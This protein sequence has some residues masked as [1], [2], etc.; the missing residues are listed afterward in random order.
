MQE[1]RRRVVG[2]VEQQNN[3]SDGRVEGEVHP[4]TLS[5]QL[6]CARKGS[7]NAHEGQM[8]GMDTTVCAS[9]A[10]V[11]V[12]TVL[13]LLWYAL[14]S[15]LGT[16]GKMTMR[17]KHCLVTGGSSGIGKE[18]AKVSSRMGGLSTGRGVV[19]TALHRLVA[20]P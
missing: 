9:T 17:G 1:A 8:F 18:V 20:G 6:V 10:L 16:N 14:Q 19:R 13:L 7:A 2:C 11:G 5:P 15:I 4:P 12:G 3:R